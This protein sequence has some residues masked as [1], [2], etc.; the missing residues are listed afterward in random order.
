MPFARKKKNTRPKSSFDHRNRKF[1]YLSIDR[2]LH[3]KFDSL[4]AEKFDFKVVTE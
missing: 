1:I 2:P 3:L 4:R